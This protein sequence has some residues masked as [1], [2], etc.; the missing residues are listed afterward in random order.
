MIYFLLLLYHRTKNELSTCNRIKK[1]TFTCINFA[2][3]WTFAHTCI[4]VVSAIFTNN[5]ISLVGFINAVR[6]RRLFSLNPIIL[7]EVYVVTAS[8]KK[9]WTINAYLKTR[10][11]SLRY[12]KIVITTLIFRRIRSLIESFHNILHSKIVRTVYLEISP[13]V[14]VR[15]SVTTKIMTGIINK[16]NEASKRFMK[17]YYYT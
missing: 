12:Q 3:V 9:I 15:R 2:A 7:Y 8:A 10:R 5:C 16:K 13:R 6:Q 1:T 4:D 14:S 11:K 17:C